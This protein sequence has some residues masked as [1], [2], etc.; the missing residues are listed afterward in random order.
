M[1][2]PNGRVRKFRRSSEDPG[3]A[4]ELTFSCYRRLPLLS[5]DRTRRWFL[6]SLDRARHEHDLE[7]W[8]YVIMPEHAHVLFFPRNPEYRIRTILQAIKQ[9]VMRRAINYLKEH[10]PG[11]LDRLCIKPGDSPHFWQPGGG[12]DRNINCAATAWHVV[13]YIHNNPVRRSL[14]SCPTDWA[15]SSARWYAGLD[16]VVLPMD[17]APPPR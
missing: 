4:H 10:N 11:W 13:E 7:L 15:W 2:L 6:E 12:Y 8:A 17:A 1:R 14:A 16:D 9:P 3:C 5:R